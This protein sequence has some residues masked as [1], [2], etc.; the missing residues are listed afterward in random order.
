[1]PCMDSFSRRDLRFAAYNLE[2]TAPAECIFIFDSCFSQSCQDSNTFPYS[3]LTCIMSSH[4][5]IA[6]ILLTSLTTSLVLDTS[7]FLARGANN[8]SSSTASLNIVKPLTKLQSIDTLDPSFES[9]NSKIPNPFP[10]TCSADLGE[11]MNFDPCKDAWE[12]TSSDRTVRTF[13]NRASGP[14]GVDLPFRFIGCE[15]AF[16]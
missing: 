10:V 3:C 15:C 14:W 8:I 1:M 7:Q 16:L 6:I 9:F 12:Y 2:A 4:C 13:G 11:H 5:L